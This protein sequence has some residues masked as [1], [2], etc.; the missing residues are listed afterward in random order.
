M[1]KP[2]R[3]GRRYSL[4]AALLL[5]MLSLVLLAKPVMCVEKQETGPAKQESGPAKEDL[6]KYPDLFIIGAQKCGTTSLNNLLF[7]HRQIC[8]KGVKEKVSPYISN[9]IPRPSSL[10]TPH[11]PTPH[12][13]S[14]IYHLPNK[15]PLFHS[16]QH[17]YDERKFRDN[18][19][20]YNRE[21]NECKPSQLTVDATPKYVVGSEIAERIESAYT[22]ETL[23]KK[24]FV[25]LL[26]DPVARQY[27]E[28]QRGL[29]IC[30]R[31]IEGDKQL[32]RPSSVRTPEEKRARAE[33]S[34]EVV[35]REAKDAGAKN[36]KLSKDNAMLF[37]EWT[38]GPY[39]SMEQARGNYVTQIKHWLGIIKRSQLFIMNFQT[40]VGNTTD[41]MHRMSDFLGI[42]FGE[43]LN[44]DNKTRVVLPQP[45]PSNSYV[46]WAPAFMDCKTHD[47]LDKYY[48]EQN[49]GLL[50]LI[51]DDPHKPKEEPHF[52]A[53]TSAR[54]KCKDSMES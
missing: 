34:C 7:E 31:V 37:A 49:V 26:R 8:S 5:A 39:G 51:N 27:S 35:M 6:T 11:L 53:F 30:F 9:T 40:L 33:K 42:N 4:G 50:S 29:R 14:T 43:F 41:A 21:F 19:Q 16:R 13:P 28:Y 18:V 2:V 10:P 12:P 38:A 36:S 46:T 47:M 45:P 23:A 15:P 3:T 24:K 25:L 32:L 54:S 48:Q 52:P 1:E 44:N 22:A 20:D 17:F